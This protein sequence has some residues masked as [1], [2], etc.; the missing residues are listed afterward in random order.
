MRVSVRPHEKRHTLSLRQS[1]IP[2]RFERVAILPVKMMVPDP[3]PVSVLFQIGG[4]P[5]GGFE[6]LLPTAFIGCLAKQVVVRE[7][8]L[9]N[10]DRVVL[11]AN[12][13]VIIEHGDT[14][15]VVMPSI[16]RLLAKEHVIGTKLAGSGTR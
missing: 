8:P 12:R 11:Q 15:A 3:Q 5:I 16:V 14:S 2:R 9:R 13:A 1:R 10:R 4:K 7:A 6:S